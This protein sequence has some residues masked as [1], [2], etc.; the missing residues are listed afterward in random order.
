[1]LS[2]IGRASVRRVAAGHRSTNGAA[3]TIFNLRRVEE[4]Q[5]K[6]L[7]SIRAHSQLQ[8]HRAY[9]TAAAS[10]TT[11]TKSATTKASTTKKPAAKKAAT[12]K[13]TKQPAKKPAKKPVKK[14]ASKPKA[15]GL[16]EKQKEKVARQKER[17]ALKQ[18]RDKAKAAIEAS[19]LE[20][21]EL[22]AKALDAPKGKPTRSF[23]LFL[24]ENGT[25]GQGL[26]KGDGLK[27]VSEK[28]KSLTPEEREVRCPSVDNF[29][30]F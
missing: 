16:T 10:K 29:D 23:T 26:P 14:V 5:T 9:A 22:K 2:T 20:L 12:S 11:S 4:T 21:T 24:S 15:K 3:R 17:A 28:F 27:A 8:T 18:K 19:K 25:A 30:T 1:M 7:A 6:R 13:T